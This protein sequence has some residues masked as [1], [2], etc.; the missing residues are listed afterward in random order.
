MIVYHGSTDIIS[1]PLAHIGRNHLDFGK[2]F[3]VTD[4]Q[5]QAVSWAM[6]PANNGKRN[7]SIFTISI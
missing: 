4:L 3:Y 5:Q 7:T 1:N 6:R 2:G